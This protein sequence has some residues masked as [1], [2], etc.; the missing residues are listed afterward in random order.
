MKVTGFLA[1]KLGGGKKVA[2]EK[3]PHRPVK[4]EENWNRGRRDWGAW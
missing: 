4:Y 2:K 1:K 3:R